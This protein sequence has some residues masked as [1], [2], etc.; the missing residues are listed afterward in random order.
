MML[1]QGRVFFWTR[2]VLASLRT[3]QTTTL[4]CLSSFF[5]D[6]TTVWGG[7]RW[8]QVLLRDGKRW[9]LHSR[10]ESL[11]FLGS[12]FRTVLQAPATATDVELGKKVIDR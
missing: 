12:T 10:M 6:V 3:R 2:R 9:G 4:L 1:V 11:A 5:C 8:H 7:A